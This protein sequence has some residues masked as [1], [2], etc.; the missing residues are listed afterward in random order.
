MFALPQVI[1]P[2]QPMRPISAII[3]TLLPDPDSPTMPST[4]PGYTSNE[5]PRAR[6][7]SH[8]RV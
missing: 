2:G 3:V 4:S 1:R 5:M 7:E 8:A 6:H